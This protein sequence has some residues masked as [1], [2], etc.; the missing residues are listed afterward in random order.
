MKI[1]GKEES[2][3][4]LSELKL[5]RQN[6]KNKIKLKII[7]FKDD[8]AN[9][10][11]IRIKKNFAEQL[12]INCDV[13]YLDSSKSSKELRKEINKIS[14][15]KFVKGV[16]IQLPIPNHLNKNMLINA[17]PEKL[18]IDCL[19]YK[20]LGKFYQG[21]N[22]IMPPTVSALDYL[23]KKHN[24]KLDN[25]LLIG[26]GELIGKPISQYLVNNHIKFININ[27]KSNDNIDILCQMS[28]V[29]ITGAGIPNLIKFNSI[30]K[31]SI[32]FDYGCSKIEKICGDCEMDKDFE[33]KCSFFT[34]VPN[35]L[36]PIVVAKLF[37]NLFKLLIIK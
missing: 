12:N 37:D 18:D 6:Y 32:I 3:I 20:N 24:L 13:H 22:G 34:P 4:I 23:I 31:D 25:I 15:E 7:T 14:K 26:Q 36:G 29:I 16:I 10:S 5:K 2:N 9:T 33:N 21:R 19:T 17:I 8:I 11:Y 27:H 1:N 28:D 30:K 35:G